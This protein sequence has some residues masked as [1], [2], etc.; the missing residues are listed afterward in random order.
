[1]SARVAFATLGCRL[2][3]VDSQHVQAALEARGFATVPFG[4]PA[5]VVVVNTCTVTARAEVSDRQAIRRAQRANPDARVVV[6]GCWAQT[7]AGEVARLPGVDLVVGNADKERLPALVDEILSAPRGRTRIEVSDLRG[8][9]VST[10][11]P[12]G[13]AFGRS[14]AFVKVQDG[15]QHRCA[16]CIVPQARGVSRSLGREQVVAQVR[17]LVE[18]GYPEITLTGVDLGHYG[19]DLVPRTSLAALLRD[20]VEIRGLRWLR[21]SSMLPAY[22]TDELFDLLTSAPA[23]APH[24]HVPLQSGSDRVLRA[25]RRP[26]NVAMY[27]VLIERL[28][29]AIPRLG[30]GADVIAGFPGE[31]DDDAHA[32]EALIDELPFTY[33]HVFPYSDRNGTE[34][35]A[36]GG[37]VD[38]ATIAERAARLRALG[39]AKAQAFRRALVGRT[40]DVL[41]L[42]TRDR[43]TGGLVGLTGSYVEVVFDGTDAEIRRVARV[44]VTGVNGSVR[45]E[46]STMPLASRHAA[47]AA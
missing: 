10:I 16:F 47:G 31:T 27:R 29:G 9:R 2:N 7:S 39:A 40:E 6:T 41:V 15:C 44:R 43:V 38:G 4:A 1:V 14:R 3:Q 45:G 30:L 37:K 21:L 32:T 18:A 42:E 22:F 12:P 34:A 5:D 28:A 33:L 35:V 13:R 20:L 11:D 23:I 46:L 24:L 25:M 8:A 17:R 19:A 36:R 26:Y